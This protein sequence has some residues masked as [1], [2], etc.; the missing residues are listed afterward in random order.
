MFGRF[1]VIL[2][3]MALYL[4]GTFVVQAGQAPRVFRIGL[5]IPEAGLAESQTLKGL[6]DELQE[7]GYIEGQ[8]L[9]IELRNVKGDRS[10]LRTAA[11]DL[12]NKKMDV[13]FT[14]GTRA[15]QAAI[16]ATKTIPI[17]FRHVANPVA[18]GFIKN[19]KQPEG[20]VTGVAAFSGEMSQKRF[21]ILKTLVT[22]VRRVHIF[23][24]ENNKYSEDNFLTAEKAAS[25][26]GLEVVD[27]PVK[28]GNELRTILDQMQAQNGDV[29]LQISDDLVESHG[30][31]L[32]DRAKRLKLATLFDDESWIS[33][34]GLATYGPNYTQM[35]RQA[36]Q[37]I[38]KLLKGAQPK[39]V[40]VQSASK[41]D[42]L[43]NLR[44]ANAIGLN[45]AP[46][47]LNKA[48]K[49]IR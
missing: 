35:G 3:A 10:A 32:I 23:Y 11:S 43:I 9:V 28:T 27:H 5:L 21:E 19:L 17:V 8:N 25:R 18:L 22:N 47:T 41:F 34:G 13:I 46:E 1:A 12:V 42:L 38:D 6:K 44:T 24:D 48:E 15:T 31:Y 36:A 39:D 2:S 30:T 20:N 33:K 7:L 45:I 16:A 4:I 26:L 40:P 49:V 14:T 29:I 37:L